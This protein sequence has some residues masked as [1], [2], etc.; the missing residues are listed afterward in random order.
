MIGIFSILT[1]SL[2]IAIGWTGLFNLSHI[3]LAGIGA[4]A[5][6]ILFTRFEL[7]FILS[8]LI[9]LLLVAAVSY[10]LSL[11]TK[12]IKGD[13]FD[14]VTLFF[15]IILFTIFLNWKSVTRGSFGI[16][17]IPQPEI[18]KADFNMMVFSC[19]LALGTYY[20]CK[21]LTGSPFG[22]VMGAVRDD[23]TAAKILG[24]NTF[25]LKSKVLVFSGIF[26]GIS[27]ILL[28]LVIRFIDPSTFYLS[29]LVFVVSALIIGGLASLKGSILGVLILFAVSEPIRFLPLP[30]A[31]IGPLR[32]IVNSIILILIIIYRPQG[33]KGKIKLH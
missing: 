19:I 23:E 32:V 3:G 14:L 4:Y 2:N 9:A 11:V 20:F 22:R 10:I 8:V 7:P 24:K 12:N 33:L 17:A 31:A 21:F 16:P 18:L 1:M 29:D 13:Q 28:A 25:R 15:G 6:T 30:D 5:W 27:G 26:A